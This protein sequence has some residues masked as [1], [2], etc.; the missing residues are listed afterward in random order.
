MGATVHNAI[1]IIV[2]STY[3]NSL[4]EHTRGCFIRSIQV[5]YC[6][7]VFVWIFSYIFFIAV[8]FYFLEKELMCK[9]VDKKKIIEPMKKTDR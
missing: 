3:V 6:C 1:S 7:I 4:N 8:I 9:F 5:Q 2:K